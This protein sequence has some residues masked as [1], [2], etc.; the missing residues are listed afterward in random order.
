MGPSFRCGLRM[1]DGPRLRSNPYSK[2]SW[3]FS[4]L[5]EATGFKPLS[6]VGQGRH[7]LTIIRAIML[8]GLKWNHASA[9]QRLLSFVPVIGTGSPSG[10]RIFA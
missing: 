6:H 7:R 10:L 9:P 8:R 2:G 3:L 5:V 1:C 4:R